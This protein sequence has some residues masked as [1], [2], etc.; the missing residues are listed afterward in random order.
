MTDTNSTTN[1]TSTSSTTTPTALVTGATRGIGRETAARLA[2]LGWTVWVGARDSEAGEK[3]AAEIAAEHPSADVRSVLLDVTDDGSVAA[4]ADT[5]RAAGTGL[6]ALV[7]N[8]G[9]AGR[10]VAPEET[11]AADFV[12]VYGTNVLGPVRVTNAFLPLL[13]DSAAPRLVMVSSGVGSFAVTTDPD[14]VE[15]TLVGLP[16]PSSK[17]ALNMI[18]TM[19]AKALPG[20]RV[21]A[22]DPGYTATDL[23]GHSG[24]QSVA[25]G[26]EAIV[27]AC[28]AETV[29]GPFFDR[30]GV[31]P[32][33][34]RPLRPRPTGRGPGGRGP[35][36][37]AR[38]FKPAHQSR[39]PKL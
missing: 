31:L 28:S 24:P 23:N 19:Y 20:V 8:A 5:V 14:R 10:L 1:T 6:D 2:A 30:H 15:S 9:V 36:G 22:V 35:G 4:A 33:V 37:T 18:T 29:P 13:R 32:L 17:A 25:E 26:A 39:R 11:T 21:S 12:Q 3:T 38:S 16:Y 34:T 27:T 7:N